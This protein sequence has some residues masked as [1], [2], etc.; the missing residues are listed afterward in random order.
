MALPAGIMAGKIDVNMIGVIGVRAGSEHGGEIIA[1]INRNLA[2]KGLIACVAL[3][4]IHNAHA[5]TVGEFEAHYIHRIAKGML[6]N[7][8]NPFAVLVAA[9]IRAHRHARH[10]L[11]VI[12][13]RGR[14]NDLFHPAIN[15]R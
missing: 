12:E 8:G 10:M 14:L 11:A 7:I 4:P 9:G 15:T 3:P 2:Q 13:H 6:G 5:A 1:R